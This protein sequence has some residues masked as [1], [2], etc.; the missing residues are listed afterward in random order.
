MQT[1][2]LFIAQTLN[3]NVQSQP[4]DDAEV[5]VSKSLPASL[6]CLSM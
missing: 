4:H 6:P 5:A 3:E 2:P 1:A